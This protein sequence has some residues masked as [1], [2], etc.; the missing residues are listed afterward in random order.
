M[1]DATIISRV[2]PA[3]ADEDRVARRSFDGAE[4]VVLA[5]GAGGVT[6]GRQAADR[7]VRHEFRTLRDP[8]DCVD[9]L[10]R[11]DNELSSD[12]SRGESTAVLLILREGRV[13]G[14]SVGDSGAW[15]LTT[16]AIFDLTGRQHRKPLLGS[17][18]AEPIGFGPFFFNDRLLVASDGLLKYAP[19]ERIHRVAF[20]QDVNAAADE[21]IAAALLPGGGL[22]DDLALVILDPAR[23]SG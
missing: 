8:A 4:L 11:L 1:P 17:G 3:S 21:L 6:G 19:R 5:D 15:A 16:E 13:F 23:L 20:M 12:A 22:Q 10:R 7:I 2:V 14:A 18:I 9:E